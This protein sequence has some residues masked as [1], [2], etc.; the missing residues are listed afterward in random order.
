MIFQVRVIFRTWNNNSL[1]IKSMPIQVCIVFHTWEN[2]IQ[3]FYRT[4]NVRD[5]H[6]PLK[7]TCIQ[8]RFYKM[9]SVT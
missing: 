4:G 5:Q 6:C 7:A 3:L 9:L 1:A 8:S 2:G